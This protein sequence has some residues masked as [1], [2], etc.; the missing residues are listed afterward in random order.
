MVFC[1]VSSSFQV[2]SIRFENPK[3]PDWKLMPFHHLNTQNQ[4]DYRGV[5]EILETCNQI[6]Y[7]VYLFIYSS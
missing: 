3:K 5:D 2:R 1:R 6:V 4:I 7:L